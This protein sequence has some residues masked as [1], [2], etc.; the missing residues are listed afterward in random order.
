MTFI[1]SCWI[2]HCWSY[3][4]WSLFELL[5]LGSW[6]IWW[7]ISWF[8][9]VKILAD[10]AFPW[11][12]LNLNW[13]QLNLL[14]QFGWDKAFPERLSP[15]H[16]GLINLSNWWVLCLRLGLSMHLII[17]KSLRPLNGEGGFSSTVN[18][19]IKNG[20]WIRSNKFLFKGGSIWSSMLPLAYYYISILMFFKFFIHNMSTIG[21]NSRWKIQSWFRSSVWLLEWI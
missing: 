19:K 15:P 12:D 2:L 17:R 11:L 7:F 14:W 9:S 10:W 5:D 18:S 20:I 8:E 1:W 21:F 4:D 13:A 6:V 16:L 3:S